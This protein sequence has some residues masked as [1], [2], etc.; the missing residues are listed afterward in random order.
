MRHAYPYPLPEHALADF[1]HP[2]DWHLLHKP[3]RWDRCLVA[4]NGYLAIKANRG[5]WIEEEFP[6]ASA[7]FIG[8]IG[9][10]PWD[11][12]PCG[13]EW[14]ALDNQRGVVFRYARCGL[15]LN[16]KL[17]P[18]PVWA[19][20]E[21][22]VRLSLL[23]QVAML[24]RCEVFTGRQD[25][26]DPLFFRFSGGTGMIARDPKLTLHSF[27]LFGPERDCFTGERVKQRTTPRPTFSQPG[28]NWPPVDTSE[29]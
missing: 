5:A 3:R 13:D 17:G 27:E 11:R 29:S 21:I 19:V 16:G 6:P 8:R 20:N 23:Q 4:A 22:R 12:F 15:W 18:S 1:C 7:E 14:R 24:P 10:L 9:K 2:A 26:H 28:R 25:M